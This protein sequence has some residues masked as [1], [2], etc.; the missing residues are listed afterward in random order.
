MF[1]RDGKLLLARDGNLQRMS[2]AMALLVYAAPMA[3][4]MAAY[5]WRQRRVHRQSLAQL[6]QAREARLLE[7]ASLH[8]K[9]DPNKCVGCQACMN[10]CPEMPGHRV[11]GMIHGKAAL[12]SPS[13]CIGH[14]ACL[15]A[16]PV[17]AITLVF[18][19]ET[20]GVD[21]PNVGPDFQTNVPGIYIAGEL[22]GM[23]LIRNAIE[24]GRQSIDSVARA[25]HKSADGGTVDVLIVGAGPAG[26]S[27]SLAAMEKGLRFLTIEQDTLGGTVAHYPRGKLVMAGTARL[28]MVGSVRFGETTKESLLQFWQKVQ[29]DT[30]LPISFNERAVSISRAGDNFE[31]RTTRRTIRA[32]HIVL[33]IGRRGTPRQLGVPG[34]ELPKVTYR[35]LDPEQY[36]GRRVMVVGG[37]DS[38]LEAATA[39]SAVAGTRVTLSYRSDG[40]NRA[41][42][43]N[44]ERLEKAMAGGRLQVLLGTEVLGIEPTRVR[45]RHQDEEL[46]L[47]NDVVIINAGGVLPTELLQAAGV[48]FETKYG[49]A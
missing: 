22:G 45:L 15:S 20:R 32:Q 27:A 24:Q 3:A 18:G 14:G 17:G 41:K 28:P 23:G 26:F 9:I 10:A 25:R 12:V 33:A 47:D 31:V 42:R 4:L 16:C 49:T 2:D 13:E 1:L 7:P 36:Q 21:I 38:A 44:R 39:I 29:R 34:E 46:A 5:G 37:G 30:G 19:T 6:E 35:L 48:R 8:P 11:L 43:A 40:F